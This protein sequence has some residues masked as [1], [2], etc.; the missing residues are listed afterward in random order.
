M[1]LHLNGKKALVTGSS[2]GLGFGVASLLSAEGA[3]VTING[4]NASS[5]AEAKERIRKETGHEPF[6]F[7]CDLGDASAAE[8]LVDDASAAMG[9]LDILVTNT[10]GP[11]PGPFEKMTDEDWLGAFQLLLMSHVRMIRRALP[12]L[13]KS[14]SPSVLTVTSSAVKQPIQ[15]L[16]LSNSLRA[17]TAGLTKTLAL[18]LGVENI[19]FNS[20]LPGSTDTERIQTLIKARM[21]AYHTTF[22]EEMAKQAAEV[23]FK[24]IATVQEFAS[25]AVFL[26]SPVASY[27]NGVMLAVDG[28]SVKGLL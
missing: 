7:A 28:G 2:R 8:K 5:L 20:I 18:E 4:R 24:R 12:Y 22:E 26:V 16:V 17:A 10:G 1:D 9:G 21:D 23:P 6:A 27:L 3:V 19:R 25:V 15:D 13:R 14:E 11:R